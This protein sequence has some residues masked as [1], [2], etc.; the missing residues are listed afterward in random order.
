MGLMP[1]Q[2]QRT[3]LRLRTCSAPSGLCSLA[4]KRGS[5]PQ[6]FCP[7][8]CLNSIFFMICSFDHAY[9]RQITHWRHQY[10]DL[11]VLA[12][13]GHIDHGSQYSLCELGGEASSTSLAYY[14]P[15]VEDAHYIFHYGSKII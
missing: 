12:A 9:R 15:Q 6:G 10:H 1:L 8:F 13:R 2:V 14:G 5:L 11:R 4:A 7:T 3:P